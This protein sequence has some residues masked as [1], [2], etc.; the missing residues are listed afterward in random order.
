MTDNADALP[1][2]RIGLNSKRKRAIDLLVDP[3]GSQME[4]LTI[5]TRQFATDEDRDALLEGMDEGRI[6]PIFLGRLTM[7][8]GGAALDDLADGLTAAARARRLEEEKAEA[9]R[10][11]EHLVVDLYT[12]EGKHGRHLLELQRMSCNKADWKVAYDRAIERDR[13]CDWLRWQKSR[14]LEFLDHAAQHGDEALA[15][16]LVDEMF[17]TERRVKKEGRGAGGS[18]PLRMWRGD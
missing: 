1:A 16:L 18:R 7:T 6:D 12:R 14:F 11:R 17:A 5:W 9:Q 13:L 3:P 10:A 4:P 15:R 8:F 2:F